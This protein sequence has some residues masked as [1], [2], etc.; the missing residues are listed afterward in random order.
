MRQ[1]VPRRLVLKDRGQ[2]VGDSWSAKRRWSSFVTLGGSRSRKPPKRLPFRPWRS[3][4][5]GDW[6]GR[7]Y[8]ANSADA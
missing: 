1:R 8:S 6:R 2:R 5:T 3:N 4:A 7:G